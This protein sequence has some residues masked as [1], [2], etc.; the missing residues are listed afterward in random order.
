LKEIKNILVIFL[1]LIGIIIFISS[2]GLFSIIQQ[3]T[4]LPSCVVPDEGG[5][6]SLILTLPE[7]K[8]VSSG[9]S[10]NLLVK[11]TYDDEFKDEHIL[12]PVVSGGPWEEQYF[13]TGEIYH[14]AFEHLYL[15]KSPNTY[16]NVYEYKI[17]SS[18]SVSLKT[19][20]NI[21]ARATARLLSGYV[22]IPYP[23]SVIETCELQDRLNCLNPYL[24]WLFVD[25]KGR[26]IVSENNMKTKKTDIN[27]KGNSN[28]LS[29]N[30]KTEFIVSGEI[31]PKSELV[32]VTQTTQD[33]YYNGGSVVFSEP[34]MKL[35]WKEQ[36][37]I[38]N[39]RVKIGNEDVIF[40]SGKANEKIYL[41]SMSDVINK[42]C[43]DVK[44]DCVMKMTFESS[45]G[46]EIFITS[47]LGDVVVS[48]GDFSFYGVTGWVSLDF[49]NK[50]KNA[51]I[52]SIISVVI[53][54]SGILLIIYGGKKK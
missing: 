4:N 39:L 7:G 23:Y 37:D 28:T 27:I 25:N 12:F 10:F 8:K 21:N 15:F 13:V 48:G 16:Q 31:V 29:E 54:I 19:A 41:P 14:T 45:R 44:N 51:W 33:I 34:I 43:R 53:I 38:S 18:S 2:A 32:F 30:M 52:T 9:Y 11:P 26:K 6:C 20:S 46:G 3:G 50:P 17:E 24:I 49:E 1:I 22:T 42:Y 35:S 47:E 5:S 36:Y 40:Y